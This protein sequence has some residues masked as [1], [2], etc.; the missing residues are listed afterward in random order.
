M[1]TSSFCISSHLTYYFMYHVLS[2]VFH[3]YVN[4]KF[5]HQMFKRKF[6]FEE[7]INFKSEKKFKKWKIGFFFSG[8][9][10]LSLNDIPKTE[11]Y[12]KKLKGIGVAMNMFFYALQGSYCNFGVFMLYRDPTLDEAFQVLLKLMTSLSHSDLLVRFFPPTSTLN[13]LSSSIWFFEMFFWPGIS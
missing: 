3:S 7:K 12:Q 5:E 6:E 11:L 4:S 10:I 1:V 9:R 8:T 13:P 2:Y